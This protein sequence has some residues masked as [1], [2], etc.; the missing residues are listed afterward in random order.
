LTDAVSVTIINHMVNKNELGVTLKTFADPLRRDIYQELA[1][2]PHPLQI[3]NLNC[4]K[5]VSKPLVSKHI[6]SLVLAGLLKR[7]DTGGSHPTYSAQRA[8]LEELH[9]WL[10]EVTHFWPDQQN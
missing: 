1:S 9:W 4:A 8:P 7:H 3:K 2:S 6:R 5:K 10:A